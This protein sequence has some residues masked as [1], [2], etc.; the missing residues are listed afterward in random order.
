MLKDEACGVLARHSS[1]NNEV[2]MSSRGVWEIALPGDAHP[3]L[4]CRGTSLGRSDGGF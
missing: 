4:E 2:R 3:R 1:R